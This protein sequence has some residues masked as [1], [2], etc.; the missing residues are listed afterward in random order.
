MFTRASVRGVLVVAA[1]GLLAGCPAR[2]VSRTASAQ[3]AV[4]QA[5]IQLVVAAVTVFRA[6]VGRC[7]I[8]EEGLQALL[9]K[10]A[11]AEIGSKWAGPYLG[12]GKLPVDG[13]K[14]PL[15]YELVK[16]PPAERFAVSSAGPDGKFGTTDDIRVVSP[17]P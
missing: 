15:K 11:D 12:G 5:Q 9:R 7:P 13:W 6:S 2:V 14:R 10:P 1:G 4:T 16:G 3:R 17:N 8:R